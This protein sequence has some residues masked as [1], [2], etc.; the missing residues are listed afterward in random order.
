MTLAALF[1]LRPAQGDRPGQREPAAHGWAQA[2]AQ[3][4]AP[5]DRLTDDDWQ[6]VA[7]RCDALA[8][9]LQQRYGWPRHEAEQQIDQ[10][11][12]TGGGAGFG[13]EPADGGDRPSC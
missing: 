13:E 8:A 12:R 1:Q 9:K 7:G 2:G 10:W 6:A 11:R 4:Q 5:W 3:P